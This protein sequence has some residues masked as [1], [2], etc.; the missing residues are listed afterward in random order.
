[1]GELGELF[2][3]IF[4][5]AAPL[6]SNSTYYSSAESPKS[7]NNKFQHTEI[8]KVTGK[9]VYPQTPDFTNIIAHT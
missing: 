2:N 8:F 5:L 6:N 1:L 9:G 7:H 4:S 3:T